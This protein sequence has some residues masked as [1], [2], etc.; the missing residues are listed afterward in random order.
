M[1]LMPLPYCV[2]H[3]PVT[4]DGGLRR[5]DKNL[6]GSPREPLHLQV[7]DDLGGPKW[8]D[9]DRGGN[10]SANGATSIRRRGRLGEGDVR[11]LMCGSRL[12]TRKKASDMLTIVL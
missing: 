5:F 7:P 12:L 1:Q 10:L 4:K 6:Q 8:V 11:R 9:D 3:K 2:L